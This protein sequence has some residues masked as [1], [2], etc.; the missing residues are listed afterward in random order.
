[1]TPTLTTLACALA[2]AALMGA[3]RWHSIA[4]R[5]ATKPLASASFVLLAF[6]LGATDDA[7]GITVLAALL[8]C[9]LGDVLLIPERVGPAFLGGLASFLLGHVGFAAAFL[10][11]GVS[12]PV[13][14]G[15]LAALAAPA[16]LVLR[17]LRPHLAGPMRIAVPAYVVV[18]TG[19]VALSIGAAV[20]E[21]A[22][23]LPIATSCF[24]VSD[25]SV[26]R[27]RFVAP[28]WIN[29]L[30]GL[31]LYYGATVML[32]WSVAVV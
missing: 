1:M 4:G 27:D 15:A 30:W 5:W 10:V 3:D 21:G 19:M 20:H 31:P 13:T 22:W 25:I 18:I 32:A 7:Y 6:Q 2:T 16:L 29:R 28:G 23:L 11:L 9:M 17:W 24:F 26:A 8:L 14:L 12:W